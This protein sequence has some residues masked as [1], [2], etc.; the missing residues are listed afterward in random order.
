M[1]NQLRPTTF[2]LRRFFS[3]DIRKNEGGIARTKELSLASGW[4]R[5]RPAIRFGG[6]KNR[7]KDTCG[8]LFFPVVRGA[9][10]R[11]S[12]PDLYRIL[13]PYSFVRAAFRGVPASVPLPACLDAEQP[14]R[15]I[16]QWR[17]NAYLNN[18]LEYFPERLAEAKWMDRCRMTGL[19]R[20]R[21]ARQDGRPV[22]LAFCHFG[23]FFLLRTWLRAAGFP[24][25]AMVDGKAES[26]S[27][28]R[29]RKDRFSPFPEIPIAFH[30]DQLRAANGFLASGNA[31]MVAIDNVAGKQMNVPVGGDW[32][33]QMAT[34]AIRLAMHHR[35][36][37]IPCS[38]V[39]EGRW[40][41]H[42]EL[43]RPAPEEFLAAETD[44]V[45]AGKHLLDELLPRLQ[46][47]PRQCLNQ[48]INCFRPGP[49]AAPMEN[50]F[51]SKTV[52]V[53]G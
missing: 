18:L 6:M 31:L 14:A 45:R 37:L 12:A 19:D 53:G 13:R 34:G 20:L 2:A 7:F 41:F 35:A 16:R 24:V 46:G 44:W 28:L 42:I 4:S 51:S 36:E 40:R 50:R 26:R 32:T 38:I 3:T 21:Q 22:V 1:W 25:A 48:L 39:D 49:P 47:H 43:G 27:G 17:G 5:I 9:E 10:R 29:R 15:A 11:L 33:F 23:P 8:T 30:L 52:S